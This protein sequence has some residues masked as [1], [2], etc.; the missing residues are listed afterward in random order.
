LLSTGGAT[1]AINACVKVTIMFSARYFGVRTV[2][3]L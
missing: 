2:S 3:V 1:F